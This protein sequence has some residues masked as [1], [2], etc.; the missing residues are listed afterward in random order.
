MLTDMAVDYAVVMKCEE[1]N[2]GLL[3][4]GL[5]LELA[6]AKPWHWA[7][8]KRK[9]KKLPKLQQHQSSNSSGSLQP[10]DLGQIDQ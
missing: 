5:S 2:I 8:F 4:R 10:T 1:Q 6:L 3:R 7:A 9:R